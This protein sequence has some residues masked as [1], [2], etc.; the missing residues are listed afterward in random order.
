MKINLNNKKFKALSNSD[1]G[2]VSD[3]TVFHYKQE[4]EIIWA[5]YA[6]GE[7]EKGFLI[8]KINN[9]SIEFTYQHLN[10]ALEIMTG[11]CKTKIDFDE[12]DKI[13][14]H[15]EWEWTCKD[16]SK[17]KSTLIEV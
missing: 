12:N 4:N 16:F 7:I 3:S 15:E 1:N 5:E 13:L 17:G 14:L 9:C 8:G 2:E 6:G 11:K 10:K